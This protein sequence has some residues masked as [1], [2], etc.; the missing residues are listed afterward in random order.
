VYVYNNAHTG[1]KVSGKGE[2]RRASGPPPPVCRRGCKSRLQNRRVRAFAAKTINT[3]V[4]AALLLLSTHTILYKYIIITHNI[5]QASGAGFVNPS[6]TSSSPGG[7]FKSPK[8][9]VTTDG[10]SILYYYYYTFGAL[11]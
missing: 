10:D 11:M 5:I 1:K 6:S 9:R 3:R 2:R 8:R 4:H 7:L